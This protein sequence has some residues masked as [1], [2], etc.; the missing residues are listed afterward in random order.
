MASED[1]L[2][3]EI[4][5]RTAQ[6]WEIVSRGPTEA[7]MR[8]PKRFS[9]GW[10]FLW[11]LLFGVGVFVYLIW[12]WLKAEQLAYLRVVEGKLV[13]SERLGLLGWLLAPVRAYWRWAGSRQTTRAKALAYGGPIVGV[14]ALVIIVAVVAGGGGDEDEGRVVQQPTGSPAAEVQAPAEGETPE[15]AK[16]ERIVAAAVGA[17]AEAEGVRIVLNA[18]ADPWVSAAEFAPD[19]PDAGKRF[20]AFDVTIEY[21]RDS[22]SHYGC[23]ANFKL[24][25]TDGFAYEYDLLFDLDPKLDC[26]DLGSG[27]KTR[28]WMGFE[29]NEAAELDLLKYDPNIF[30]TD[31]VEFHFQ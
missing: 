23:W 10:A 30:T 11:F 9:F 13:V 6:G 15:A 1:I 16:P 19:R 4:G 3:A 22:G 26:V 21:V 18:I 2:Q 12:H 20:V 14:I 5:R 28:G 8:R 31:D 17:V 27:Q 25:D 7:Q 24:S 29:V